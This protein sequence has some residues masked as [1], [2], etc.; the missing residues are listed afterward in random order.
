[1]RNDTDTDQLVS[2]LYILTN[3]VGSMIESSPDDQDEWCTGYDWGAT[4]IASKV[5]QL[6]G[7]L[8][9][10][11][12]GEEEAFVQ[13]N[14]PVNRP[15]HYVLDNGM[16]VYDILLLLFPDEPDLWQT[17]KYLARHKDKGKPL[18]DLKK[19]RWYLNKK[20]ERMEENA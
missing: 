13:E 3:N 20:I 8:E 5:A 19:A 17:G 7:V 18:Q 14:D 2:Q 1:M 10:P 4:A 15:S 11:E 16:E 6:I 12:E 9:D